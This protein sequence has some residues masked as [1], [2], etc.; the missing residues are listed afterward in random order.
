MPTFTLSSSTT[1]ASL[2]RLSKLTRIIPAVAAGIALAALSGC[3]TGIEST[4]GISKAEVRRQNSEAPTPEQKLLREVT[5]QPFSSWTPGKEFIVT[6]SKIAM[7]LTPAEAAAG[8]REGDVIRF[9]SMSPLLTVM[10]DSVAD[11]SFDSPGIPVTLSYR[12]EMTPDALR[13]AGA[14]FLPFTV[15]KS[16]VQQA[17]SLL[18]GRR[19]YLLTSHRST[20]D[21]SSAAEGRKFVPVT[22]DSVVAGNSAFPLRLIFTDASVGTTYST[23]INADSPTHT[24][25]AFHRLF[26]FSDPRKNYPQISD[27]VWDCITRSTVRNEMTSIECRL[28]LGAPAEIDRSL[29]TGSMGER[30]TYDDGTVLFFTD[31]L[32]SRFRR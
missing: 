1:L 20:A 17:D 12:S 19:L 11:I 28:A 14:V 26:S 22:V 23:F 2:R 9:R 32:L 30:W 7:V 16:M 6:D 25:R 3:F 24:S 5:H 31:G 29:G 15:E 13:S 4:P 18:R 21:G 10:G 8:L 27:E